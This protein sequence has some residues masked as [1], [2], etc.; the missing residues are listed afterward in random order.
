M[1]AASFVA[2]KGRVGNLKQS[3]CPGRRARPRD[4]V[5]P[6]W[7]GAGHCSE[8]PAGSHVTC[9][10][11]HGHFRVLLWHAVTYT[12]WVLLASQQGPGTS[13]LP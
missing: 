10:G 12:L 2:G 11:A 13:S 4:S 9:G 6:V 3:C 1:H 8:S 7:V 5:G